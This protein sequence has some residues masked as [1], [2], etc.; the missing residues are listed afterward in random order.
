MTSRTTVKTVTFTRPFVLRSMDGEQPAGTYV[1]E[2]DEDLIE[3]LSFAAYR[4]TGAWIRLPPRPGG[5]G[6]TS[7]APIDPD[8]LDKAMETAT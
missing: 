7:V 2:I 5:D 6:S 4:R 1:V 3:S 8:E